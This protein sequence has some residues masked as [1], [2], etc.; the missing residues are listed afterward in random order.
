MGAEGLGQEEQGRLSAR[1]PNTSLQSDWAKA[2]FKFSPCYFG[3]FLLSSGEP[4]SL[5]PSR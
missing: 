3:I 4:V 5:L 1:P 2:R